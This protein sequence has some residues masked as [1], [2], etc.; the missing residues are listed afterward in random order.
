[1]AAFKWR[2]ELIPT[3]QPHSSYFF[4]DDSKSVAKYGDIS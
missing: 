3:E 2:Y 4:Q 1:M